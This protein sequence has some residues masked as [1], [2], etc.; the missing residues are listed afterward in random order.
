MNVRTASSQ[1]R[2]NSSNCNNKVCVRS[3]TTSKQ[4]R[5]KFSKR[6]HTFNL[7]SC[8][9][10]VRRYRLNNVWRSTNTT[11]WSKDFTSRS[12]IVCSK[13]E[14]VVVETSTKRRRCARSNENKRCA[15]NCQRTKEK[16]THS[17]RKFSSNYFWRSESN[18]E[19]RIKQKTNVNSAKRCWKTSRSRK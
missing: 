13:R 14:D 2:R 11:R 12:S 10:L 18:H 6:K 3:M 9:W 7:F 4:S 1:R 5:C 15:S 8:T 17:W 16:T 19:V